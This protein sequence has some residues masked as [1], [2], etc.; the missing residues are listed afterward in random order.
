MEDIAPTDNTH[1]TC[2]PT[3]KPPV[4]NMTVA[5]VL[6]PDGGTAHIMFHTEGS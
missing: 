1:Q 5:G 2:R 3:E 6:C 4:T